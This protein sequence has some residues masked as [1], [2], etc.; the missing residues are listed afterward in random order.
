MSSCTAAVRPLCNYTIMQWRNHYQTIM[1]PCHHAM[2]LLCN[3][4]VILP[5]H[6]VYTQ[7]SRK[8]ICWLEMSKSLH[9]NRS[10]FGMTTLGLNHGIHPFEPGFVKGTEVLWR[11]L[12]PDLF[13]PK[14][15]PIWTNYLHKAAISKRIKLEG[16]SWSRSLTNS[17]LFTKLP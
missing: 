14:S 8:F 17:K 16:P 12:V 10:I 2:L 9:V 15:F 3:H 1:W 6:Y 13:K 5:W 4:A 11:D 7:K